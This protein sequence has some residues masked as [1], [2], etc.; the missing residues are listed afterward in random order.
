MPTKPLTDRAIV[1]VRPADSRLE[2]PDGGATGLYLVVQQSGAK[3]WAYRYRSPIDGRP[4]KLTIG[5]YPAFKLADARHEA[6]EA[7]RAV[8][9]GIDPAEDRKARLARSS[10]TS[11]V[12]DNLLDEFIAR[13]VDAKNRLATAAETKRMIDKIVR[14][15]WGKRKIQSITRRD[16][17]ALLDETV[18]RGAAVTANRVLA[19]VRKFTNWCIERGIL[20]A[21]PTSGI[22]AP[23]EE[24]S[25]DR[26]LT[27]N[28]IRWLWKAT[29]PPGAFGASVR[30]LLL[31]G[32]RRS[33]VAGL[34]DTELD[35][36]AQSAWTIPSGRTKNGRTQV[37]PLSPQAVE[38]LSALP[39]INGSNL[40]FTTDGRVPISGWSKGKSALDQRM[41]AAAQDDARERGLDPGEVVVPD[42]RLHDLRR[43]AASGMARLGHPIHVVE[44][45][46]NHKSGT[47]SGVAAIYNRHDYLQE[48]RQALVAWSGFIHDLLTGA[49]RNVIPFRSVR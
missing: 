48:K 5:S 6:S 1:A 11:D 37:V 4:R 39:R 13:H 40:L 34:V 23:T 26:V 38:L 30:M 10:D 28:E 29:E 22:K 8:K 19:L 12:V 20:D 31:T 25:R 3:S 33:E 45:V 2:V 17:V 46:L 27:D 24:V 14:P 9:H 16:V 35:L 42:W 18:D 15:A 32:Q 47:V 7:A 49:N 41:L 43:T 36:G 44:A 21:S